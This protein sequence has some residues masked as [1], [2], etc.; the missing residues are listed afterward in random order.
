MAVSRESF[1]TALEAC[2]EAIAAEN[3]QSARNLYA[4]ALVLFTALPVDIQQGSS[5]M[6]WT[7]QMT[8][9]QG[10]LDAASATATKNRVTFTEGRP[11]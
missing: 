11:R 7:D 9:I 8:A 5:R 4:R 2:V 10:A 1:E 6:R 3:Y